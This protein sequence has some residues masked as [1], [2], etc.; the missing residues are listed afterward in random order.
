MYQ[1]HADRVAAILCV[2]HPE[3]HRLDK[4]VPQTAAHA[5]ASSC[6]CCSCA[7]PPSIAPQ[8]PCPAATATTAAA[9][10]AAA[11]TARRSLAHSAP[12]YSRW[13]HQILR[14]SRRAQLTRAKTTKHVHVMRHHAAAGNERDERAWGEKS[15]KRGQPGK[16]LAIRALNAG[17]EAGRRYTPDVTLCAPPKPP[18]AAAASRRC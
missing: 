6:F 12:S 5:S 14:T 16:K 3:S 8:A 2:T 1:Y 9:T 4:T 17:R 13:H 15:R 18:Q 11:A 10:A 7:V